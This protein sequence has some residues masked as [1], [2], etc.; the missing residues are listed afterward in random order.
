MNK[1]TTALSYRIEKMLYIKPNKQCE[2]WKLI[3]KI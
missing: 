3:R 2:M 1:Q